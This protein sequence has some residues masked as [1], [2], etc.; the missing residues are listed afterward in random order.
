[1]DWPLALAA[2]LAASVAV[3]H[4]YLGERYILVRLF[5]RQDLPKLFGSD[6]FTKRTLRFAWHIT[7]VAWLGL[8]APLARYD[9]ELVGPPEPTSGD[10]KHAK[11]GRSVPVGPAG[12]RLDTAPLHPGAGRRPHQPLLPVAD[13]DRHGPEH[14]G[15]LRP[16]PLPAHRPLRE[17]AGDEARQ[18]H[19][20]HVPQVPPV[21]HPAILSPPCPFR[22]PWGSDESVDPLETDIDRLTREN[23]KEEADAAEHH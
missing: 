10:G 13:D 12:D 6:W 17:Q 9:G 19:S 5:K 1:M 15:V 7:S 4:S 18:G 23:T 16:V 21:D 8:A 11:A 22:A 3:A 14:E 2:V 20:P